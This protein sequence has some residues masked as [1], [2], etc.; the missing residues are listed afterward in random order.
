MC[1]P[2]YERAKMGSSPQE[3]TEVLTDPDREMISQEIGAARAALLPPRDLARFSAAL[4]TVLAL[5]APNLTTEQVKLWLRVAV[6]TLQNEPAQALLEAVE[7]A[8]RKVRY[9]NEIVPFIAGYCDDFRKPWDRHLDV[10]K[11]IPLS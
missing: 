7:E 1:L 8:K 4:G 11:K 2:A 10:L 9:S 6:Q 3:I 5:V